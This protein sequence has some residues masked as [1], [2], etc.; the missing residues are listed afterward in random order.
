MSIA[1]NQIISIFFV[2]FLLM[3]FCYAIN[4]DIISE[5]S[6]NK[7]V[8]VEITKKTF[9]NEL[10]GISAPEGKVFI[11]LKTQWKNIHPKQKVEKD[12]L[13]GKTDRTM[14]VGALS[15]RK[16]KK[17]T[18]Y[19]DMDVVYQIGKFFDHAYLLADGIAYSLDKITEEISEGTKIQEAFSIPKK[20][21]IRKV[22][23]VYSVPESAKNLGLQ[24]FDY[25]YGHISIPVQGDLKAARG[26]GDP[27]GEVLGFFKN[28]LL[29]VAAHSVSFYDEY[30]EKTVPDGWKYAI[31]QISGKSLSGRSVKDILQIEPEEYTWV[32]TEGGYFYYAAGGSTTEKGMI[33]FTPEIFQHQELAFLVPAAT[34]LSQL[35]VR[36]R[37]DVFQINLTKEKSQKIP[38]AIASHQDGDVMEVK[39]FGVRKENGRYILNLGIQSLAT[40]G[41]EIQGQQQFILNAGGEQIYMDEERT[42]SLSYRPP[43]PFTVPPKTFVRFELAYES[44]SSPDSLYFRGYKSEATLKLPDI[45]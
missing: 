44:L 25:D 30:A 21:D 4:D 17:K 42:D 34:R 19:V 8:Q 5:K 16:E 14:G 11:I 9:A 22:D 7:A 33:R 18:E 35:G 38:E 27:S 24:F 12:K 26:S 1:K 28:D 6:N 39:L 20:G 32:T 13:E 45:D 2:F 15:G 29:E 23:F 40:S 43:A 36:I 3:I 37:N 41:I 10:A 31:V